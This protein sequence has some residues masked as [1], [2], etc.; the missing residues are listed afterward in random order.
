MVPFTM[1]TSSST[2]S[3]LLLEEY[4]AAGD[5][6]FLDEVFALTSEKTQKPLAEKW[7]LDP[8]PFA[9]QMLIRYIDH[10]CDEPF[11][12]PMVKK[13]FKL[14]EAAGDDEIMGHFMVAFDGYVRRKLVNVQHYDYNTRS[15]HSEY[16]LRLDMKGVPT[17]LTLRPASAYR[18][19]KTGQIKKVPAQYRASTRFSV[20]TRLYLCRRAWRY[21]RKLGK[22]DPAR[23]GKAIRSALMLYVDS[24]LAATERVLDAWGLIH[25]LY[26]NST[27]LDR[28]ASG[29]RLKKG[30]TLAQLEP[31]PYYPT[32]WE[33]VLEPILDMA[34]LAQSRTVRSWSIAVLRKQYA[35]ELKKL[36][37]QR[38]RKLLRSR[39]EGLQTLGAELLQSADGVHNLT[40]DE[41]F[42]L[43]KIENPVALPL[44]CELM[45]KYVSPDR[46]NIA[47]MVELSR[48][49]PAPVAE[50][51]FKWLKDKPVRTREEFVEL[52]RLASAE[53]PKMREAAVAWVVERLGSSDFA[54]PGDLRELLDSRFNEVRE[55]GAKLLDSN[56]KFGD[57]LSL[58]AALSESPYP[59][60]RI[61]LVK[62]L[63]AQK[64]LSPDSLR[65]VWAT[66][67][68][69]VHQGGR[70]KRLVVNQ[71]AHRIV[72]HPTEAESL[73]PL[74]SVALRSVRAPERRGALAALSQAAFQKPEL[75]DAINRRLPEL[76]LFAAEGT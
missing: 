66:A 35:A 12:R 50:A 14:A 40:L 31:A 29:V 8:R 57:D 75:R 30:Q 47:Q 7:F 76:K 68:L 20:V 41:W 71:V 37:L 70:S 32:T 1:A 52:L 55:Q 64:G 2:G 62:R 59:D 61:Y 65:H 43:L 44:I 34:E 19:P 36:S 23:Y 63:Q 45:V 33:G 21:F 22:R 56:A 73:L 58:W 67:L 28:R 25:A 60:A 49:R 42:E 10:G 3:S 13:L 69:A 15:T 38:I 46:L 72:A 9:R 18:D 39:D 54:K 17:K 4:F 74:L 51:G 26:G 16:R 5:E 11:H 53:S 6:R 27:V 48:Q 24:K